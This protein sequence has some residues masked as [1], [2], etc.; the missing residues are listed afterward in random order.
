MN[1]RLPV[2]VAVADS[3]DL[4]VVLLRVLAQARLVLRVQVP[5][6]PVLVHVPRALPQVLRV[7][8]VPRVLPRAVWAVLVA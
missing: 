4:E 6:L 8:L 2:L 7:R 1:L 3:A 5:V